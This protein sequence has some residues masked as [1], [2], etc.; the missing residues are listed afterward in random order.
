MVE[1]INK[2]PL[3]FSEKKPISKTKTALTTLAVCAVGYGLFSINKDMLERQPMN[4][5]KAFSYVIDNMEERPGDANNLL[6]K[7]IGVLE[8]DDSIT[9]DSYSCMFN[10]V[11]SRI[12]QNPEQI[13][14]LC[15]NA[16]KY[17]NKLY[18][19]PFDKKSPKKI[20]QEGE[21]LEKTIDSLQNHLQ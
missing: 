16:Q 10:H 20:I 7:S 14:E 5:E 3:D 19:T 9:K 6:Q 12:E 11:K 17:M 4:Y 15:G 1:Y 21:S 2:D 8:K 18:T 13:R